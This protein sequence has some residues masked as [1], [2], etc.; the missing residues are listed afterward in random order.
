MAGKQVILITGDTQRRDMLECYYGNNV[1]TP[2]FDKLASEGVLFERAYCADPVC[3]PARSAIFTGTYP[4]TNGAW[5]NGQ[6][7]GDNIANIGQRLSKHSIHCV[8]IGKWHLDGGSYGYGAAPDGWDPEWW[9]DNRNY[10]EGLSDNE[11]LMVRSPKNISK[12]DEEICFAHQNTQRALEF[13]EKN[14]DDDFLLVV[15][16]EEPHHPWMAP[17]PFASMFDN[18]DLTLDDDAYKKLDENKPELHRLWAE[19]FQSGIPDGFIWQKKRFL[20]CNAYLDYEIGRLIESIDSKYPD[21]L[22]IYTA[23]HG[24]SLGNR[25]GMYDKG[26]ASY[27]EITGIPLIIRKNGMIPA[28]TRYPKPVSH[29]DLTPTILDFM[30][31]D[32]SPV[33]AG[34]SM[35]PIL[36]NP[37][38]EF[39]SEVFIEF[40]RFTTPHDG[41]G[42]FQPYRACVSEEYKLCINLL[43]TDE[44]YNLKDDPAELTNLIES[45][46]HTAVRNQLHD[47]IIEWMNETRDP[48]R[49]YHWER[50]PWRMDA[51][52]ASYHGGCKRETPGDPG[53]YPAALD[54]NT[55]L[56]M[57]G[58]Y[59]QKYGI[60]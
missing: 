34:K 43:D 54:Y 20:S 27:E 30:G 47:R 36:K 7:M 29:I 46:E 12:V 48:F 58:S 56:P 40:G 26:P 21:A 23:D 59:N 4:H 31:C 45:P 50:R 1:R 49:G 39:K 38:V 6:A 35:M 25:G 33:L 37:D 15:E 24:F 10:I 3:T 2:N 9:F 28:G 17:E 22:I 5:S 14:N 44:L 11:R 51:N 55:G 42:G 53:F 52:P 13:I 8:H 57:D 32:I 19:N 41:F 18:D 16:Y 60:R